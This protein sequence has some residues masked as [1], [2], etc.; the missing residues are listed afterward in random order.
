MKHLAIFL[1]AGALVAGSATD[2][3]AY[4]GPRHYSR[5]YYGYYYPYPY[6]GPYYAPGYAVPGWGVSVCAGRAFHHGFGSFCI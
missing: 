4:Y 5:P 2:S 1:A 6:Y 3:Q